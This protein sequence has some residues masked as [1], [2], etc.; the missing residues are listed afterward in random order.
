MDPVSGKC[1]WTDEQLEIPVKR[2][3]HYIKA[4][5]QGTFVPDKEND[6]LKMALGNPK[7]PGW[8]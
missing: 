6:E 3:Q 4:A 2:L 5:Q 7:H 8:T 1:I